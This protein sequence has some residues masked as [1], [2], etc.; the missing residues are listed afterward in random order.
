MVGLLQQPKWQTKAWRWD[1]KGLA[2]FFKLKKAIISIKSKNLIILCCL[3]LGHD[4]DLRW[5][6]NKY[7]SK[8]FSQEMTI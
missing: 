6:E 8:P 4:L 2:Q 3:L 5:N 1:R 7:F